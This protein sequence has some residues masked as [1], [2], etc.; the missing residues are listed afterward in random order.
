MLESNTFLLFETSE[1]TAGT[2]TVQHGNNDTFCTNNFLMRICGSRWGAKR[3]E[4]KKKIYQ[5]VKQLIKHVDW[6]LNT[7]D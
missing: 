7:V 3:E 4:K 2:L 6:L 5:K 1:E